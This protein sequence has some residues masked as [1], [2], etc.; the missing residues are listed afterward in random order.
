[1]EYV[2]SFGPLAFPWINLALTQTFSLPLL[3]IADV[4]GS[5]GIS[6]WIVLI[7]T[8][9]YAGYG[10][11]SGLKTS[12]QI[13]TLLLVLIS[14]LGVYRISSIRNE[15]I[16]DQIS[17]AIVQPN[18]DPN[19]KWEAD[20][21]DRI[22]DIMDSLHTASIDLQPDFILWPEAALPVYLRINYAARRPILLPNIYLFQKSFLC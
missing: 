14:S 12:L 11:R 13:I 15:N 4:T 2:R 5:M 10:S 8:I 9:L 19:Q 16:V 7:N 18:I 6:F 17:T 3:Q 20:F 1:M 21:R 22:F